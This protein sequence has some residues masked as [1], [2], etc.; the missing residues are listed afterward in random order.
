[1]TIFDS[2]NYEFVY[3]SPAEARKIFANR[4]WN[5][6]VYKFAFFNGKW[7]F[8][9]AEIPWWYDLEEYDY[10]YGYVLA[11]MNK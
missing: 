8:R 1:M 11:P 4:D 9:H 6:D 3:A 10:R 2:R 7:H 5:N